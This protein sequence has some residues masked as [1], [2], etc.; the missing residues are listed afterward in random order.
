MLYDDSDLN[1]SDEGAKQAEKCE[2]SDDYDDNMK[3]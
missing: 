1:E 2:A 3:V